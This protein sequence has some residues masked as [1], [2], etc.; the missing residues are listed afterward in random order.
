MSIAVPVRANFTVEQGADWSRCIYIK[1]PT[2]PT[3]PWVFPY[4]DAQAALREDYDTPI[5]AMLTVANTGIILT[6]AEGKIELVMNDT[7]TSALPTT[8][9]PLVMIYDLFCWSG[10]GASQQID[11]VAKGFIVAWP[12]VTPDVAL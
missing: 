9:D 10:V 7:V 12:R 8:Y 5:L 1:D 4:T 3:Q 6:P 11:K 2:D